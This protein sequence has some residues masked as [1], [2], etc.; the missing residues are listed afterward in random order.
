MIVGLSLLVFW[1]ALTPLTKSVLTPL[2]LS[3]G[4][5][6]AD[7]AIQK[8]IHGSDHPSNLASRTTALVI[9]NEEME[10]IMKIINSLK[11]SGLLIEWI[12]EKNKNEAKDQKTK[13]FSMLLPTLTGSILRKALAGKRVI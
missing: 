13:L 11:E 7:A 12:S 9:L 3:S 10:D 5:S 6:A 2:G 4:M 8:K 1:S